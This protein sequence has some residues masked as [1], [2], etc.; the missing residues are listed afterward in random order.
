MERLRILGGAEYLPFARA[1]VR[2]LKALGL[3]YVSQS[4]EVGSASIRVDIR[5]DEEYIFIEAGG[6]QYQFFTTGGVRQ[7]GVY[8]GYAVD[9]SIDSK[10]DLVY[11]PMGSSYEADTADPPRWPY[12]PNAADM[13]DAFRMRGIWQMEGITEHSAHFK[14]NPNPFI[15]STW[16]AS[17]PLHT[18]GVFSG[19]EGFVRGDFDFNY[20]IAPSKFSNPRVSPG[21]RGTVDADWYRRA[22]QI[23]VT[24]E[25]FGDRT[26][27]IMAD[28]SN[29]FHAYPTSEITARDPSLGTAYA[30]QGIKTGIA[31]KF[32]KRAPAP[33]PT[34]CRKAGGPDSIKARDM[35]QYA[36]EATDAYSLGAQYF[37]QYRWCFNST[38]TRAV[39]VVY[40]DLPPFVVPEDV[41]AAFPEGY[42]VRESLPGYVEIE[43]VIVIT[44]KNPEDFTFEIVS[45]WESQPSVNGRYIMAAEYGWYNKSLGVT[46]DDLLVMEAEISF[47]PSAT[48]LELDHPDG[49]LSEWL[50]RIKE[51][52]GAGSLWYIPD[53]IPPHLHHCI[54]RVKNEVSESEVI[55]FV[56]KSFGATPSDTPANQVTNVVSDGSPD[57]IPGLSDMSEWWSHLLSYD[58]RSLSFVL[59]QAIKRN[60]ANTGPWDFIQSQRLVVIVKGKVVESQLID[61]DAPTNTDLFAA[62]GDTK[63]RGVIFRCNRSLVGVVKGYTGVNND[64]EAYAG[65]PW[66]QAILWQGY[67]PDTEKRYVFGTAAY[68]LVEW[69]YQSY[70]AGAILYNMIAGAF[71][72]MSSLTAVMSV[73]PKNGWSV[74]TNPI[75]Y[76]RGQGGMTSTIPIIPRSHDFDGNPIVPPTSTRVTLS[77]TL[78]EADVS[79]LDLTGGMKQGALDIICLYD[80]GKPKRTSHLE[81]YNKAYGKML[82]LWH[83]DI[84][85]TSEAQDI[86]DPASLTAV[87]REV[88]LV[89]HTP[90]DDKLYFPVGRFFGWTTNPSNYQMHLLYPEYIDANRVRRNSIEGI[91]FDTKGWRV[92]LQQTIMENGSPYFYSVLVPDLYVWVS[93]LPPGM[94][95]AVFSSLPGWATYTTYPT[96]ASYWYNGTYN[97]PLNNVP[98]LGGSRLFY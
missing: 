89:A 28:I 60:P 49:L 26:F 88:F 57:F 81:A 55:A 74:V 19:V 24:S 18:L 65:M 56:A 80:N 98:V 66:A 95:R 71:F 36:S 73:H 15:A 42:S 54:I 48:D 37:P 22:A 27:I 20:D 7:T 9:V 47:Y 12:I 86:G 2:A 38:G 41:V 17:D 78:T 72:Q 46:T 30:G 69:A 87:A 33:L 32:V 23:K 43:F 51:T 6:A 75:F 85:F 4:Y 58:L 44:D 10:G 11:T 91:Y 16:G 39:C 40:E 62:H 25:E 21:Q 83:R 63:A 61:S 45:R 1:R 97:G 14:N 70:S 53:R 67:R 59:Q 82:S 96:Y 34:W 90:Y 52:G 29:M 8:R 3:P 84:T 5:P 31:E 64:V 77:A 76:Y 92:E 93:N 35:S 50:K 13:T 79:R 68:P 94:G